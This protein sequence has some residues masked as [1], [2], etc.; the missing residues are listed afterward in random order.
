MAKVYC[1]D[2]KWFILGEPIPYSFGPPD[3]IK[4]RCIAPQ[5]FQD[6]NVEPSI[7]PISQPH[8]INRFNDCIWYEP[9]ESQSSSSSSGDTDI[10]PIDYTYWTWR[11]V[12][13]TESASGN[14]STYVLP[15]V[16]KDENFILPFINGVQTEQFS[17]DKDS[18]SITFTDGNV[19]AE[20]KVTVF[21]L[22]KRSQIQREGSF[23][24]E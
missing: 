10:D 22:V 21:M 7:V 2:C 15:M 14:D 13:L 8:I 19:P 23:E 4:N 1:K 20:Y 17:Y 11:L 5:N 3:H 9:I 12:V 6:S 18:C 24:P 16:P